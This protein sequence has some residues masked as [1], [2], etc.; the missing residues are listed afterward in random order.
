MARPGREAAAETLTGIHTMRLIAGLVTLLFVVCFASGASAH[1]SLVSAEPADGSVLATAPKTVQLQF[2][3]PVTLAVISLI[4]ASGKTRSD[5]VVHAIDQTITMMLPAD[6]PRGTQ[7]VSYR[8]VSADGHPVGGALVFSIGEMTVSPVT[9]AP[10]SSVLV[11]GL[12]WLARVGVYL[13]LFVGVGGAFFAAWIG[14][15]A[16]GGKAIIAALR[17]GI[18]SAVVSLGLQG[19]DLQNLPLTDIVTLAPWTSAL[20]TSLGP[21]LLIAVAAMAIA[22]FALWSRS[23]AI[24]WVLTSVAILAVG[25][26]LVSSGHAATA[27]PSW[28]T[29]PSLFLHGVGVAYWVGAL[30]PLM[31]MAWRRSAS[32]PRALKDFSALA[33]PV[34]GVL[35]LTGLGLAVVQLESFGA[36]IETGYGIVLLVKLTLVVLLLGLAALNRFYLTA[37]VVADYRNTRPLLRSV[38]FEGVLVVGILAVVAGWRFTP[39]PRTLVAEVDAPLAVHIHTDAAMFQVLVSPGKVGSDNFV[40]QLMNGDA[41][42]LQAKEAT[43]ILSLPERGI[44]PLERTA[45]LGADGYWHVQGVPLP[46]PGRWHMRIEALVTDFRKVALEDELDIPLY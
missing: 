41:A 6:L 31:A 1:A 29:R 32:L 27:P 43:L 3:E 28:L 5:V 24:S 18:V 16:D 23:I 15:G 37:M 25:L 42:P 22:Y 13:G 33:V 10:T 30:A 17:I 4:D 12:I 35:V 38:V 2:N 19:I 21:S 44:E 40:L 11:S 7:V 34:V 39:P 9:A 8:I 36:L 14:Q 20:A 45:T 26:S 46:Y